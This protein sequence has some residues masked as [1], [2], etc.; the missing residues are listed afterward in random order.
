MGMK[1]HLVC[2][3]LVCLVFQFLARERAEAAAF[4]MGGFQTVSSDGSLDVV[5]NP[6]LVTLQKADNSIGLI[7][8]YA[9]YYYSR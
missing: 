7:L 3:V 6:S 8:L 9:P 2:Y 4:T 5:R 1:C